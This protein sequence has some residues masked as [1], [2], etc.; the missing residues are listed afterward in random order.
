MTA[1][2]KIIITC[3]RESPPGG[4]VFCTVGEYIIR[5]KAVISRTENKRQPDKRKK[6]V[7]KCQTFCVAANQGMSDTSVF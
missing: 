7:L 4:R 3:L 5:E 1:R 2:T 6:P